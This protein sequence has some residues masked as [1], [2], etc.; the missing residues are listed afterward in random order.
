MSLNLHELKTSV[1]VWIGSAPHKGSLIEDLVVPLR[2]GYILRVLTSSM[3]S[4][5]DMAC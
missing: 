5:I 2:D 4:F 3:D 1:D